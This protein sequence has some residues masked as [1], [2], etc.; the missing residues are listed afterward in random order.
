MKKHAISAK[1]LWIALAIL[2]AAGT[3]L[4]FARVLIPRQVAD[5]A[6]NARPRGNL[7][8]LYPRWLGARE[9]LLRGRDPYSPAVTREIQQGY[10]GRPLESSRPNDPKDQQGFAYPVYVAFCLAP[11]IH[12]QFETVRKGFFWVLLGLTAATI[13]LWLRLLRWPMPP[14]SEASLLIFTIGSLPVMQGLKLQQ[15]TLLVAALLAIALA[16]LA[17]DQLIAAGV[18][19]AVATIKPQLSALLLL[20]LLIWTLSD[21]RRRYRLAVSFL[22]TMAIFLGLSECYLPHWIQRFWQAA[23]EYLA[24]TDAMSV[25]DILMGGGSKG[26]VWARALELLAFAAVI[27][28]CWKE[29]RLASQTAG[30]GEM[31]SLVLALTV[32]LVPTHDPYNQVLL[33]PAFLLLLKERGTIWRR[34][35]ANRVCFAIITG[36]V[37]W[38]WMAS[39]VL[40]ALSFV[41]PRQMVEKFWAVPF[42]TVIQIPVATAAL[43]LAR[44]YQK[45][46]AAPVERRTS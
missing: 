12:L 31:A 17:S 32:L 28:A 11:T 42:W 34:S 39:A 29:R 10:Y 6:V 43:M 7:S 22:L 27:Y 44:Y 40:A 20:W 45:A 35:I 30:F 37:L 26:I 46:F 41:L 1:T 23:H 13:P 5:A 25:M 21:W 2:C 4:Y 19:L 3:W 15:I 9:L 16:L 38:P 33:L 24:Y 8:D 36:L 18:V 14:S